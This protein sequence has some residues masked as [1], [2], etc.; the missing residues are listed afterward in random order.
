MSY[1]H[2]IIKLVVLKALSRE[3]I[4]LDD[5]SELDEMLSRRVSR[6]RAGEQIALDVD[7]SG[8]IKSIIKVLGF[9]CLHAIEECAII[10]SYQELEREFHEQEVIAG[11]FSE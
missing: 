7:R 6:I 8:R 11:K 1:Q 10:I 5:E 3:V 9:E 2:K 4:Y